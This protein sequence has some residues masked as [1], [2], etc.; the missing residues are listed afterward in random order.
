MGSR[1][2]HGRTPAVRTRAAPCGTG[3]RPHVP[4]P[5]SPYRFDNIEV[6]TAS[7]Q[8]L[9]DGNPASIGARAFDVLLA[10]IAHRDRMLTKNELLEMVWPNLVVEENNLQVHVSSLRK[11]L[12]AKAIVTI[13]GRGYRFAATLEA[14]APD[15]AAPAAPAAAPQPAVAAQ[16]LRADTGN[17]PA[18]LAPLLGRDTEQAALR[19]LVRAHRLVS[20]L[21][22]GGIGKTSLA[23]AVARQLAHEFRDGA[24]LVE[25]ATV[26]DPAALPGAVALALNISLP[27][28]ADAGA[29]LAERLRG[30]ELLVLDNCEHLVEPVAALVARLLDALP[31][32]HILVT[33]QEP[34]RLA[35]EQPMRLDA[36]AVPS[37]SHAPLADAA[38]HGAVALFV[39]RV[40]AVQPGF[41][42]DEGN[43]GAVVEICRELDGMPLA[44]ELAAARVPL[45]GVQGARQHLSQRLRILSSGTRDAPSRHRTLRATLDWSHALLSPQEQTVFRR[46]GVFVGGFGLELA[47]QVA[48]DEHIDA[49]AVLDLLGNLIDKSI[50]VAEAGPVPRYRLLESARAYAREQSEAAGEWERLRRWHARC[51]QAAID[52]RARY[53]RLGPESEDQWL[54]AC[55]PEIDNLGSAIEWACGPAGDRTLA[56]SLVN[57]ASVLMYQAGRYPECLRWMQAAEPLIGE[58]TPAQVVAEFRLGMAAAGLHGGISAHQ[59]TL[60]LD[61]ALETF[62]QQPPQP[63][64]AMAGC[65]SAYV[66]AVSGDFEKAER[67]LTQY[68]ALVEIPAMRGFKGLW[69]YI[70]GMVR[71]YQDRPDDAL[72][73][74]NQALPLVR[75]GGNARVL[76]YVLNNLAAMHHELGHLDEAAS[77]FRGVID[78][79]QRSP[80]TD[81]QMMAF[82]LNWY[83]HALTSLGELDKAEAQVMLSLP[84]CRRSVGLRHFAG[85]LALLFARQGRLREA[86]LLIGC[87]DAARERRGEMRTPTDRRTLAGTLSLIGAAHPPAQVDAWRL[88][89]TGLDEDAVAA[90]LAGHD[91]LSFSMTPR[92]AQAA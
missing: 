38:A 18:L 82:A 2:A 62:D 76:F 23:K 90:L 6:Q 86:A 1:A 80:L 5:E 78:H 56:L 72:T 43:L 32:L 9:V 71:R 70:M 20:V 44:L 10:L 57:I 85:M 17:L 42:L 31:H 41:R 26:S 75:G 91:D 3:S 50:V 33:S 64:Q 68:R 39:A 54:L 73:A 87:D 65:M 37:D 15:N 58:D 92:Y 40:R 53:A 8:L 69:L 36:L 84:H 24:W 63:A 12:G 67:R 77:Q 28:Q 30:R 74:F 81:A 89:G 83:A 45:L 79:L 16:A 21:G 51:M 19:D 13:P 61:Q 25:L 48:A 88:E 14:S 35:A 49:W 66:A 22:P 47:Q 60:L 7:R 55:S 34:L 11:L 46:L 29:A 52:R 59:R 27:A 4:Q